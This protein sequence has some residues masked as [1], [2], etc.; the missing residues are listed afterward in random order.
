MECNHG[1]PSK[2]DRRVRVREIGRCEDVGFED[3]D[4][5]MRSVRNDCRQPVAGGK[6]RKTERR[7]AVPQHLHFRTPDLQQNDN[8][9]VLL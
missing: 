7:N 3:G 1:D 5:A 4:G 2:A 9:F 6:A 8:K